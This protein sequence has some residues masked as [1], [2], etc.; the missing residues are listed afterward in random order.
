MMGHYT[1]RACCTQAYPGA[2]IKA[3][4]TDPGCRS[5]TWGGLTGWKRAAYGSH[6]SRCSATFPWEGI[7][8]QNTFT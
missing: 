4:Q 2:N 3:F 1:I 6:L 8:D 7:S 5:L